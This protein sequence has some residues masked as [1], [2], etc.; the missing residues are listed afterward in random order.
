M[1]ER[2]ESARAT[3]ESFAYKYRR[4]TTSVAASVRAEA[5]GSSLPNGYTT[6]AQAVRLAEAL[7]IGR[8]D[9]LLDLGSGRGWP[10]THV[11]SVTGCTPVVA[12]L[13]L[14]ALRSARGALAGL[15]PSR[16]SA[17]VADGFR[18]PFRD[19]SFDAACHTDVLC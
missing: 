19:R 7:E 16:G 14:E 17:V 11:A 15:E 8:D 18:L 3:T 9:V 1:S 5:L 13:P 12:D 10:G 4:L 6:A 2:D